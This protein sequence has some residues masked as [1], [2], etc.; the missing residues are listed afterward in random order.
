MEK[1]KAVAT[2][3]KAL[4]QA[5]LVPSDKSEMEGEVAKVEAQLEATLQATEATSEVYEL[6]ALARRL[7]QLKLPLLRRRDD[8]NSRFS[9]MQRH[10]HH[11]GVP[12]EEEQK[13]AHKEKKEA[14]GL[15]ERVNAAHQRAKLS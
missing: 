11:F 1:R 5:S 3:G 7:E 14:K 6:K 12:L 15:L 2:A 10:M 13:A 4:L 8:Y 9:W